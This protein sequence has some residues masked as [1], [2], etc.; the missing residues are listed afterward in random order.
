MARKIEKT[1]ANALALRKKITDE[2]HGRLGNKSGVVDV[3]NRTGYSYVTLFDGSIAQVWRENIPAIAGAPVVIGRDMPGGRLKIL[4]FWDV[5]EQPPEYS[6]IREHAESHRFLAAR[7]GYDVVYVE[8]RQFLPL[9]VYSANSARKISVY[10]GVVELGG[11][12]LEYKGTVGTPINLA[13]SVPASG[14]RW[15][16]VSIYNNAGVATIATTNG[17]NKNL[18]LLTIADIPSTPSGHRALAAVRV[19]VG[20]SVIQENRASTDIVDLRMNHG[21]ASGGG[22]TD[23]DFIEFN[24]S[25]SPTGSE[26]TGTLYWD[27]TDR[28]LSVV[29]ENGVILQIGQEGQFWGVNKT[30]SDIPNGTPVYISGAQGQRPTIAPCKGDSD[31]TS[32]CAGVTTQAI[33][34]NAAG[35]VTYDGQVRDLTTLAAFTDGDSVWVSKTTSGTLVNAEPA[36]PHHS[37][38]VGYV[39]SN[40]ATHGVLLVKIARHRAIGELTD[41]TITTPANNDLL[42][43]ETATAL[44]KN[45]SAATLGVVTGSGTSGTMT[46][47]NG[48]NTITDATNTDAQVAA[49][50]TASHARQHAITS[51]SDHTSTATS[52]QILK[53]DAN[54]LPVNATNTDAQVSAAVTASHARAHALDS[55]SDH[56]IGS[57]TNTYLVKSDG[58]KLVP[59]TNTDAQVSAAVT[60]SHA[61]SH[62]ITSTSDHTSTATSGRILQADANGLPVNATNTNTELSDAVTLTQS[63]A[64]LFMT[65]GA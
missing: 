23:V 28:T 22:I 26:P 13:S 24:T 62:S 51:T 52:G 6:P 17:T 44:W 46:K 8:L 61:R 31:T 53:A 65:M 16:L 35:Y 43:Y 21:N 64:R 59:A 63:Y 4:R 40:H 49:A 54:G 55:T 20:Q 45:K 19:F 41:T 18:N 5:Y 34:N 50:V 27:A 39:L 2:F 32:N 25:Y 57:L 9:R 14:A 37:D 42:T 48:T 7:G 1:L 58:T 47:W 11:Q 56:T 29:L 15:V 10:S 33:A 30:G 3:P 60:A 12:W 36:K 38:F